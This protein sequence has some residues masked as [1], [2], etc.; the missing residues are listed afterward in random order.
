MAILLFHEQLNHGVYSGLQVQQQHDFAVFWSVG[1]KS[2]SGVSIDHMA[3]LIVLI[4]AVILLVGLFSHTLSTAVEYQRNTSTAKKCSDLIDAILLT[5]GNFTS[6]WP[7][8]FG[9]QDPLFSQ[10]QVSPFS[11][12]RLN[13]S[14]GVPVSYQK[15]GLTYSNITAGSNNYL[16]YPYTDIISYS[17]A[18]QLLGINGS[19]G[20][21]LAFTPTVSISITQVSPTP[22]TLSLNVTGTGFPLANAP[23]SYILIPVLLNVSYPDFETLVANQTGTFQTDAA[24]QA[25][26][27]FPFNLD[28]NSTYV[29]LAYAHLNGVAGIGCYTQPAI[30]SERVIPF[31]TALSAQ[32][33]T[34]AHGDDVPTTYSGNSNTLSY[35][36]TFI[37]VSQNYA[38]QQTRLATSNQFGNVRSNGTYSYVSLSMGSY[39]PGILV[40][41][42]N[43]TGNSGIVMVPWGFGL[44]FSLTFGGNP[45][46]QGWVSTDMRQVQ[47]NG[48]SYQATLSLWST[49]G[50]QVT[51]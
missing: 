13:S 15:T 5:P 51:G 3:S 36:S 25:N 11:L 22:L 10:Y 19:Y 17:Y 27:T 38:L 31:L 2:M 9:L 44:G 1:A 47:I 18:L 40:V 12:M 50:Y 23:V 24:G 39:T 16:L 41:A 26:I 48:V 4:A 6:G 7:T 30:G 14:L 49:Q 46:N 21:K 45:A 42:Y 28:S 8:T 33:V 34:L 32:N 37:L 20:F 43:C 35:N 29:F